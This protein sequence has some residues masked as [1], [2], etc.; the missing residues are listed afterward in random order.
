M[1]VVSACLAGVACRYNATPCP[2]PEILDLVERGL[3]LPL[4]PEILGGLPVP[5]VPCEIL[6]GRVVDANGIDRTEAFQAGVADAMR[7][8]CEFG[9]TKAILKARSPSCGVGR[10]YDGTFTSRLVPGDGFWTRALREAGIEVRT[11]EQD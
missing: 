5:R 1:F 9:A 11:A 4:C 10:I 7:R 6:Y 2:V 3:A 8:T